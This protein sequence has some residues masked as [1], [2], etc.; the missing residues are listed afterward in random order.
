M[1]S[2]IKKK[3]LQ[4]GSIVRVYI[5][6]SVLFAGNPTTIR[7]I[8]DGQQPRWSPDG[9]HIAFTKAQYKGIYLYSLTDHSIRQITDESAAGYGM[10]WSPQGTEIAARVRMELSG[11]QLFALVLYPIDQNP[12]VYLTDYQIGMPGTPCW[13][14]QGTRIYLN[15]AKESQIWDVPGKSPIQSAVWMIVKDRLYRVDNEGNKTQIA[16]PEDGPVLEPD[17]ASDNSHIALKI[18][19]GHLWIMSIDGTPPVN[20]GY[21]DSPRFTHDGRRLCYVVIK[22][23]GHRL[24][25]SDIFMT[26]VQGKT[27]VNLT[28]SPD[29]IE[30]HPDWSPDDTRIVYD[31]N[32]GKIQILTVER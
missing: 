3:H 19:G 32:N 2:F 22:D 23:N 20:L 10:V 12:P 29:V 25:E 5:I 30:L 4:L 8:S 31:T 24:T 15:G 6:F 28:E 13:D 16:L 14:S 7:E 17:I 11:R 9:V 27:S 18:L 26:D 21:G 1:N